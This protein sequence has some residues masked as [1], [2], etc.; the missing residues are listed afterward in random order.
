M[1][2]AKDLAPSVTE[3]LAMAGDRAAVL[4][5][6]SALRRYRAAAKTMLAKRYSDGE[7]DGGTLTTFADEIAEV[8][9]DLAAEEE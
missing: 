2:N 3:R 8:E 4:R 9:A 7:V 6:V 1:S 5:V